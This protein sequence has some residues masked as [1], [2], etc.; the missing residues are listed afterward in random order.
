MHYPASAPPFPLTLVKETER[1]QVALM[2]LFLLFMARPM[3]RDELSTWN[4]LSCFFPLIVL[5]QPGIAW[6][7][8]LK[9]S[10]GR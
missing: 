2:W 4:E 6:Q 10:I 5:Y 3:N 7:A 1:F 9:V 8:S